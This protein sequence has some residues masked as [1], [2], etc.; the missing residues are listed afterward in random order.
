LHLA[1]CTLHLAPCTLHLAPCTLHLA[2]CTLH[3]APCTL[4]LALLPY[5]PIALLHHTAQPPGR[6]PACY[7]PH[8]TLHT[9]HPAGFIVEAIIV[10]ENSLKS[11]QLTVSPTKKRLA[12]AIAELGLVNPKL[13]SANGHEIGGEQDLQPLQMVFVCGTASAGVLASK[14]KWLQRPKEAHGI[15]YYRPSSIPCSFFCLPCAASNFVRY[16]ARKL[17]TIH[18]DATS[19][20]LQSLDIDGADPYTRVLSLLVALLERNHVIIDEIQR[21]HTQDPDIFPAII[22]VIRVSSLVI[23]LFY[24]YLCRTGS[25]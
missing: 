17:A 6:L 12:Q 20:L 22:Q 15:S 18:P 25:G 11:L 13:F 14:L 7:T 23:S 16:M 24:V 8:P 3:L 9:P 5:C 19:H 1:P 21:G 10:S 4:P 2:P